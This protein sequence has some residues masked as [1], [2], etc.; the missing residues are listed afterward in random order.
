[1]EHSSVVVTGSSGT[2][3][4]ALAGELLDRG[5]DVTGDERLDSTVEWYLARPELFDAILESNGSGNSRVRI[6]SK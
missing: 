6:V 1:M 3:G 4:T 5:Y 2:I